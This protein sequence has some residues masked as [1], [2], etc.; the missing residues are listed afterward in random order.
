MY[1]SICRVLSGVLCIDDQMRRN[2]SF[3]VSNMG[4]RNVFNILFVVLIVAISVII[5]VGRFIQKSG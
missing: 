5:R 4:G 2:V 1:A 3:D